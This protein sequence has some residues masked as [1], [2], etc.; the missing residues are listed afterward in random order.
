ME[1]KIKNL[2]GLGDKSE[3]MLAS[4]GIH[5]VESFMKADPFELYAKLS[6][7][8]DSGVSLNLL[9]AMIGAQE[10]VHWQD[11]KKMR[12]TE[13]LLRLDDMGLAPK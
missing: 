7:S 12:K 10:D 8:N 5:S 4:I 3:A 2:K 11:V 6:K 13:I 1:P 9:Y